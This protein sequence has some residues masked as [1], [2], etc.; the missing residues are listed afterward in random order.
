[1]KRTFSTTLALAS[2]LTLAGVAS[3]AEAQGGGQC[4]TP[5][6]ASTVNE[7]PTGGPPAAR[8]QKGTAPRSQLRTAAPQKQA[9]AAQGPTGPG[10]EIDQS[11]A[12][13]RQRV[14]AR[15]QQLLAREVQILNRLVSNTRQ[16]NPQR[17]EILL[18]LAETYFE[19][20]TA[21]N[22]RVRSFDQPIFEACNRQKNA[23]RCREQRQGQRQ[24][25][26][27]LDEA[28]QQSIRTYATLVNDH[29]D[30]GRMDEVL[31]SLA[32]GLEELRETDRARQV[33][34]R[35]IKSYPQ[36]RFIP[37]AYLSFAEFYF[38]ESEMTAALQFYGKVTEFPPE[39]NPV[40]GYALYKSAWAHYNVENF[41]GALQAFVE[42]IEFAVANP[43]A[44]D[45][46][47]LL[48]QSRR[49]LVLPYAMVGTPNRA[50]EFFQ[51]YAENQ[52]QAYD[53]LESLAELYF[54][55]GQWNN[56]IA[57]YHNLM[58]QQSASPKLCYWQSRV[59]NAVISS[60]P[61]ADQVTEIRR[62]VDIYDAFIAGSHPAE[63]VTQCKAS[64]AQVLAWLATSWH[65]EAIG[66]QDQPGT[67]DRNT[68]RL[69][70]RL[71]ELLIEKFPDLESLEFPEIARDDWPTQ[72]KVAY[73]YAELL[74][75]MEDW[76]RC[77]PAFDKV[78]E[79][80]PQGEFTSDAAYAAVLCYNNLYQQQY[81]S[82]ERQTRA[83][84][85]RR[86]A[87]RPAGRRGRAAQE[88][89][90]EENR[91]TRREFNDTERGMLAA[92]QRY[93]CF[94]NDAEDL[95]Q[96]KYRRARIYYEA[97][98]YEEAAVLFRD[99]AWN[100]RTSELAEYAANLYLDSLNVM[101]SQIEPN[102]VECL[103]DLEAAI[104]PLNGFYCATPQ[105]AAQHPDL[106]GVLT[107][108]KCNVLRKQ[109]EAYGNNQQHKRAAAQ[110]VRIFR[111]HQECSGEDNFAM[112]EVLYNAAIHFEAARLL[113]RAIQ[114]RNVLIERFPQSQWAKRALYLV[115]ANFHALAFYEQAASYYERFARQFPG[116]DGENCTP[117]QVAANTCAKAHEALESAV[118][119]RIGLGQTEQAV[120]DARLF[121]RN[122]KRK[123]PADTAR[124]VY[125]IG[126]IYE[127]EQN[128]AA[129]ARH[130]RQ[131]LRDYARQALP[132]QRVRANVLLARALWETNDRRTA[133]RHF[134][135]A[136]AAFR[137][138]PAQIASLDADDAT[139]VGY[140]K[141]ALDS[142]AEALFYLAEVKYEEFRAVRFPRYS[143][144]RSLQR[145]NTWAQNE[146]MTWIRDKQR[147]LGAAEGEFNKIA[148]LQV[149]VREGLPPLTSPPWL[150]AAA[151]RIGQ[152]YISIIDAVQ[153]APIPEEIENDPELFDIYVGAFDEPL[154]P[155]RR[156]AVEKFE[157]CLRTA[158]NVR[159]FNEYS[160]ICETELNRL[161]ARRYP[162]AAE[163][164]G[165][166]T[167]TYGGVGRPG[168]VELVTT[169][170]DADLGDTGGD[171]AAGGAS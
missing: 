138:A 62:M 4:I 51:R 60:K 65:R 23:A 44:T 17:P 169:E 50:L 3:S 103:N 134:N 121:E 88:A 118:L 21:L 141:E 120:E 66:T 56:A 133:I 48:R 9:E 10:F 75:K 164:R 167:Y 132:N 71:Y 123:F 68:M 52:A 37:H 125:A 24:A 90:P 94:V 113:G 46:A 146:F 150:I 126:T 99:I 74:W 100:H 139:K 34:H 73:Y 129:V 147:L 67:N 131:F 142:A 27:Q 1:M 84:A 87:R 159:W 38:N 16:N 83:D 101:G 53:M 77:G 154:E 135:D 78:V 156:Q 144:G 98:H 104:D 45:A 30:F 158:T 124:V 168:P 145:V 140:L 79:L 12:R 122:Y 110:Y 6:A 40:Y 119:F 96:I 137:D 89:E 166:A 97:N 42:T 171:T 58:A 2:L 163:L 15:Q 92:F 20:Q 107:T 114:V 39:R 22:A 36:S 91:F 153:T 95:P 55:T 19:M 70:T 57:V 69:A 25:T 109:A 115:G 7:C 128:W 81:E 59:T 162:V 86:G 127:R 8:R 108:L 76:S 143:G 102:R 13:G 155:V 63:S 117:E 170:D 161:D 28:R 157:F 18:R 82:R 165:N 148:E 32:F 26:A 130:F 106:C 116:E 47:N 14:Q 111:R 64:T 80:N 149:S 29:P 105:Q 5:R 152:M 85:S 35:L 41:R 61:K 43:Q 72:Y 31:F 33:Y 151:A 54:D 160:R 49:E 112:D 93:V 136:L 11:T